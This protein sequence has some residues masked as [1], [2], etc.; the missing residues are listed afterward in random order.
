M[1]NATDHGGEGLVGLGPVLVAASAPAAGYHCE[2]EV[3]VGHHDLAG[4]RV[5]NHPAR[6][7]PAPN[8]FLH[9]P[10]SL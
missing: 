5:R 9:T 10:Q 2:A 1:N 8:L 7:E 3:R 6:E 4:A